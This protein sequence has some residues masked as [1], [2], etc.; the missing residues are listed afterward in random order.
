MHIEYVAYV[1][2]AGNVAN[3]ERKHLSML[4]PTEDGEGGGGVG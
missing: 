2:L 3:T 4:T 1:L